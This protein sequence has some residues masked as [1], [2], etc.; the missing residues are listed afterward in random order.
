MDTFIPKAKSVSGHTCAQ[1][2]T[3]GEGFV[4]KMPLFSKA[5]FGVSLR[6]FAI[7]LGIPNELQFDRV[8]YQMAPHSNFQCAI[9]E[10]RI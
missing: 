6:A 4:W 9:R 7:Q 8:A 3:D 1:V 5:K 2:F 10:F